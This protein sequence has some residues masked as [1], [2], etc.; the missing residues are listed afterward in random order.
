MSNQTATIAATDL[1]AAGTYAIDASHSAVGFVARHLMVTK[2]RGQFTD[3]TGTI[4]IA[5]EPERSSVDVVIAA[6]SID[7]RSADRDGHLRS[8]DFLDVERFP[9]LR[10]RS[11][12]VR[13]NGRQWQL[14]GELTVRDVTR[15]VVLDVEFEGSAVDPWGGNR[16]S[17][18][19]KGEVDREDFGI[20]WN[21]ALETGGVLVSKKVQI[22]L[23][24]QAVR[25]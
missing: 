10:Y 5:E 8:P 15:T 23:D 12:G 16:I 4:E 18:T 21:Q 25:Q 13:G 14:E 1:P 2:V 9:E 19:A 11:T 22:E 3:V 17:F 6:A 24:V 20:T 7:T